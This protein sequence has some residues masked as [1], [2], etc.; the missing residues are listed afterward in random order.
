LLLELITRFTKQDSPTMNW[1]TIIGGDDEQVAKG[2]AGKGVDGYMD[3]GIEGEKEGTVG[4]GVDGRFAEE[5]TDGGV[6]AA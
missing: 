4:A 2:V 6:V 1:R 5:A 3:D